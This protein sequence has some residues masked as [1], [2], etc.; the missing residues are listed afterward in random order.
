MPG[1]T[2]REITVQELKARRDRGEK[3]LVLDVR[4]DWELQLARIPDVVHVPMSQVPARLGEFSRDAE[5]IVM[6]HAGGRSMRVAQFLASQ[7]FGNVAN[8]SGG[9][10]AWSELVDATVPQY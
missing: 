4:E 2:I 8:L 10:A 3:P 9:I 6:C 7:G 5:T 1:M